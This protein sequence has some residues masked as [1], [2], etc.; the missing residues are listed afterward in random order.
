MRALK[1]SGWIPQPQSVDVWYTVAQNSY[2]NINRKRAP[3]VMKPETAIIIL[4]DWIGKRDG[5]VSTNRRSLRTG[6]I[7]RHKGSNIGVEGSFF[8]NLVCHLFRMQR[9]S[10]VRYVSSQFRTINAH[11]IIIGGNL[12]RLKRRGR[13]LERS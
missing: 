1:G 11:F 9:T 13:S 4:G 7:W 5:Y 10:L 6:W 12:G 8:L 2:F 3:F